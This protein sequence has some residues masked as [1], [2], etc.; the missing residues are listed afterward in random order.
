MIN[1]EVAVPLA[2][3]MATPVVTLWRW[4][5]HRERLAELAA[6]RARPP[7]DD[8]RL[9]RLEQ[10]VEAIAVEMERVG[11]GQRFLTRALAE[12]GV[13]GGPP[14]AASPRVLTPH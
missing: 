2:I 9:A 7:A 5:Q 1:L 14:P 12:R 11:E 8:A 4:L 13:V 3:V 6:E 10:A